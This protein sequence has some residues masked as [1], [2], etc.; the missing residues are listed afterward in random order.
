MEGKRV[1]W[2]ELCLDLVFV[3]AIG[4]LAHLIVHEP[5]MRSAHRR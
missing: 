1:S 5:V 2:V 4:R 3:P